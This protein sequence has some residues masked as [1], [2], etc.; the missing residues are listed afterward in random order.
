MKDWVMIHK[1]RAMHDSGDGA[2]IKQISRF[3]KLSRNTVRKYLRMDEQAI[4]AAQEA[5][6]R[7]KT[8]DTYRTY[9]IGLLIKHS[10]LK[11]PKVLRKL[12][13]K[14][15][16][17]DVS[18]R[19]LRRYLQRLKPL[20]AAAQPRYYEP[21]IDAVPG[22]QCQVDGGELRDVKIGGVISTVYFWVFVLSYSRLMYV[23]LSKTPVNTIRFIQMHDAAFRYFGGMPEECVYD[24]TKL[25]VIKEVFREV[26]FNE[27]FYR[28]ASAIGLDC[29]VCEGYDPE[30]KAFASH[31]LL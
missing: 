31:C 19:T 11:T 29:R 27:R 18:E 4:Q 2:S 8:L 6:Q 5:S 3:Y 1:I 30:S 16:D 9:L 12:K 15:P 20:V 13:A 17:L 21:V 24:Q 26:T 23:S 14:V 25:V 7:R 22:V 28:Y 10:N